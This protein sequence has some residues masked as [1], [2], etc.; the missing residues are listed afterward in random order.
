M[1]QDGT[2]YGFGAAQ[3]LGSATGTSSPVTA[4]AGTPDGGGYWI[5]TQ[6]GSVHA[7][8]DAQ[9]FGTLPGLG[10][11]PALPVIGIVHTVDTAGYWLV[12]SDGGIFAF[13]ELN[14]LRRIAARTGHLGQRHC[15][16][17]A[18]QGQWMIGSLGR[19]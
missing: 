19:A 9:G 2:V 7:F 6:N 12:G 16:G 4:I 1:A 17:R 18:N 13:P 11:S 5:V 15:G 3:T 8:G 14:S 10:V